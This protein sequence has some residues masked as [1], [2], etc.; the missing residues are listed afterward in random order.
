M[1]D[2]YEKYK[3]EIIPKMTEKFQ[4]K[5]PMMAPKLNKIV[6]S[7]GLGAAASDA[8]V[9]DEAVEEMSKITGQRPAIRRAKKAISNFHLRQGMPVGCVVTLRGI[10]MYEFLERL[11]KI[12]LPRIR[13][14]RGLLK[15]SFP[16]QLLSPLKLYDEYILILQNTRGRI[17]ANQNVLDRFQPSICRSIY[18]SKVWCVADTMNIYSKVHNFP[19]RQYQFQ[20]PMLPEILPPAIL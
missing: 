11:I 3:T 4:Y 16:C 9:M 18:V 8:K 1:S 5:N 17:L 20:Q 12:A 7:M 19:K 15:R 13:D 6:V 14:F 10:R 2:Y